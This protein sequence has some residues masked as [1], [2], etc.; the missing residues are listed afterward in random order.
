[1]SDPLRSDVRLREVQNDDLE[2][3]FEHQRDPEANRMAAVPARGRDA[4]MAHWAKIRADRTVIL[5]TVA[6]DGDVAGNLVSWEQPGRRMVGYW[7]GRGYWGRG[8]ATRAL[9]L[10]LGVVR[11]RPLYA[12]VAVHNAGSLRV[13]EKCGFRRV[14]SHDFPHSTAGADAIDAVVL[15]LENQL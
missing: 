11:P 9:T 10:F 12:N 14:A 2:V 5:Q 8:I 1:M 6:V 7:V 3:F 13:L 15:V 4:F